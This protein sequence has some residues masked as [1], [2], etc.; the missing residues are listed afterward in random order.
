MMIV[1][2]DLTATIMAIEAVAVVVEAV[3]GVCIAAKFAASVVKR[4]T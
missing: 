4:L 1:I 2:A 3:V